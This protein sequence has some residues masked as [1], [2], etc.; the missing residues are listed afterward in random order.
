MCKYISLQLSWP[1]TVTKTI[2]WT[3][4]RWIFQSPQEEQVLSL[5]P[6]TFTTCSRLNSTGVKSALRLHT[7]TRQGHQTTGMGKLLV[8]CWESTKNQR[9]KSK[10][11]IPW[12]HLTFGSIA[13]GQKLPENQATGIHINAQEGVTV[14]ANRT[15]QH[16]W[17]HVTTSSNLA[18]DRG[19]LS[20]RG[21]ESIWST[22]IIQPV[23][24]LWWSQQLNKHACL[25]SMVSHSCSPFTQTAG[26][27]GQG[28]KGRCSQP[29]EWCKKK[30]V[31]LRTQILLQVHL[32]NHS[33]IK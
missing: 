19:W 27:Y 3:P 25:H 11:T 31:A 30:T 22:L 33:E 21:K 15:L 16:F 2:P 20:H 4:A 29:Q 13:P 24:K 28:L 26:P 6:Y 32:S 9:T 7:K 1:I 17:S 8:K 12:S 14:E 23:I 18:M 5:S 10:E